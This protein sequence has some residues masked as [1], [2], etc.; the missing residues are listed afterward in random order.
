MLKTRSNFTLIELLVVRS[1]I[2]IFLSLLI[3]ALSNIRLA[4]ERAV[5][6]SYQKQNGAAI[7]MYIED[8]EG[9]LLRDWT[10]GEPPWQAHVKNYLGPGNKGYMTL[11]CPSDKRDKVT[12]I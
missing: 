6:L 11:I 7:S 9:R 10:E 12:E 2:G 8:V 3:P 4:P 1:I 5:C